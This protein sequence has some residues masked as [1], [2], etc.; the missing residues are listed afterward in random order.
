ML[1]HLGG[2]V[3]YP[4]GAGRERAALLTDFDGGHFQG[5]TA[6]GA[7]RREQPGPEVAIGAWPPPGFIRCRVAVE[8][9]GFAY[10]LGP[11]KVGQKLSQLGQDLPLLAVQVGVPADE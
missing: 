2:R 1:R 8:Q 6:D 11:A 4:A 10:G 9:P 5:G 7:G 3:I